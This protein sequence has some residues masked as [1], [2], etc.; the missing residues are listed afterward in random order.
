MQTCQRNSKSVNTWLFSFLQTSFLYFHLCR[1]SARMIKKTSYKIRWRSEK[2]NLNIK[3]HEVEKNNYFL[4]YTPSLQSSWTQIVLQHSRHH[5]CHPSPFA[6]PCRHHLSQSSFVIV[7]SMLRFLTIRRRPHNSIW[8]PSTSVQCPSTSVQPTFP[9]H[10]CPFVAIHPRR[11]YILQIVCTMY[12]HIRYYILQTI[13][14]YF[15][16]VIYRF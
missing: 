5:S 11:R 9:I 13:C 12:I 7:P 6:F 15:S 3:K 16:R 2:E 1:L 10:R 8:R 14:M 4:F